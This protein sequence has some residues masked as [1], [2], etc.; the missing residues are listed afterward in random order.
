MKPIPGIAV[1]GKYTWESMVEMI[2]LIKTHNNAVHQ[3]RNQEIA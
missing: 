3:F 2:E 1:S